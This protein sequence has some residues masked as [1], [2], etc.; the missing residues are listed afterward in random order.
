MKL[1]IVGCASAYTHRPGAA[2]SCYLVESGGRAVL[3]DMGQGSFSE[4]ARYRS[5]ESLDGVLVSHLHADHLVDLVPLRHYLLYEADAA[6]RVAVHGPG[7]L[8]RR[9]DAFQGDGFLDCMTGGALEPGVFELAGL[10]IEARHVTHIEDSYAFRVSPAGG[11]GP[12]LVYSGDCARADDLVPLLHEGDTLLCEAAFG[13]GPGGGG[14]H[15]TAQEAARVAT[16]GRVARLVLTHILDRHDP[17]PA[18]DAAADHYSGEILLARP[19][20]QLGIHSQ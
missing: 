11:A 1:T 4:L 20:L 8:R 5:A 19:G 10:R 13:A 7:E 15:I 17:E 18:R 3:L 6:G 14:G 9:F 16:E 2:S 12:G